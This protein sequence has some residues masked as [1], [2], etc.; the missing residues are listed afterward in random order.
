MYGRYTSAPS[1]NRKDW[2][3]IRKMLPYVWEYKGRVVFALLALVLSKI[4]IVA[5]PLLL[6]EIV[7][8]LDQDPSQL[9][10]FPL[11]LFLIYGALRLAN[12][13]FNEL[14]DAIFARVRFHAMRR[15]SQKVLDHL[16]SL[17]LRFHLD[18]KTGNITRDMDR[19]TSSISSILNYLVFN[20]IPTMAEFILVAVILLSQYESKFALIT[21]ITVV[22]YITFTFY[23]SNGC[24]HVFFNKYAWELLGLA[25]SI[26]YFIGRPLHWVP[27]PNQLFWKKKAVARR[28][29]I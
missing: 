11:M 26:C 15:L 21:F 19:G 20:I 10:V 24:F 25:F 5:V 12:S 18:R 7:D 29:Q 8:T 28:V 13:L 1:S 23:L 17:S 6:K 9:L 2:R 16:H 27:Y 4:A 22:V 14:R 3:N